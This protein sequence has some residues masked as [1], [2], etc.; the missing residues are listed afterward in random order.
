[1]LLSFVV[2]FVRSSLH[3]SLFSLF[4]TCYSLWLVILPF[5]L[6]LI[7]APRSLIVLSSLLVI[8]G[9]IVRSSLTLSLFIARHYVPRFSILYF[10]SYY[11]SLIVRFSL[12][13]SFAPR[14]LYLI[15][16]FY[17][18]FSILRLSLVTIAPRFCFLYCWFFISYFLL[19][20]YRLPLL[21]FL[22]SSSL[23]SSF[24]LFNKTIF[25]TRRSLYRSL[26][27][28]LSIYRSSLISFA[29]L[30]FLSSYRS[31]LAR[32]SLSFVLLSLF[33]LAIRSS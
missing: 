24:S 16:I 29:L 2:G 32:S 18:P 13:L 12:L 3:S 27:A 14:S 4:I 30:Y 20:L 1:M 6:Y 11:R 33:L 22:L 8:I 9:F 23:Y 21:C 10:R 17:F 31:F 19:Y 7:I 26:L 15:V 25:L 28:L 5:Y